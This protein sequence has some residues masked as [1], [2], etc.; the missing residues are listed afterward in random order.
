MA[1]MDLTLTSRVSAGT[2]GP[3]QTANASVSI[4]T[5]AYQITRVTISNGNSDYIV[6]F[7]NQVSVPNIFIL[8]S[9]TSIC[10]VNWPDISVCGICAFSAG[11][12]GIPFKDLFV[13]A[14][15]GLALMSNLHFSNSS[16]D[17][18]TFTLMV[19]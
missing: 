14:G 13:V 9:A 16:G 11:S 15:S 18:A 8:T 2:G 10:R 4:T 3:V 12:A 7:G 17:S 1:T 6:S 5:S 19:G